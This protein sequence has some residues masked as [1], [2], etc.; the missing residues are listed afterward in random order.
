MGIVGVAMAGTVSNIIDFI[1][2]KAIMACQSELKPTRIWICDPSTFQKQELYEYATVAYPF[3]FISF[4]NNWSLQQMIIASGYLPLND[5]AIQVIVSKMLG[6]FLGIDS[7]LSTTSTTLIGNKLGRG[8]AYQ[9]REYLK[10]LILTSTVLILFLTS[11][12]CIEWNPI[13]ELLT[14][15]K[16]LQDTSRTLKP[17]IV[18]DMI[19]ISIILLLAGVIKSLGLQ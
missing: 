15:V 10:I 18:A 11:I 14:N 8:D 6:Y 17:F 19:P 1:L 13:I 2:I 16:D 9:A 7:V 4:L 5:Q 3:I 12:L